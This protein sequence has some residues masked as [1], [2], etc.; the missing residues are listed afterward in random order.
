MEKPTG[1]EEYHFAKELPGAPILMTIT[2][3][4]EAIYTMTLVSLELPGDGE[5]R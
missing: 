3:D 1:I 5:T 4:G 2:R